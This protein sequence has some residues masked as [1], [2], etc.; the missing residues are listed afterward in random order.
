MTDWRWATGVSSLAVAGQ[1]IAYLLGIVVARNLGVAAFETYVVASAAFNLMVTFA[2]QGLEK[3]ALRVVPPLLH[4]SDWERLRGFLQFSLRRTL[5]GS[6]LVGAMVALW[7]WRQPD[8]AGPTRI[9]IAL[10]CAAVPVGAT[11]NW[12]LE[13]LTALQRPVVATAISRFGVPAM[14]LAF[15]ALAIRLFDAPGGAVAIAC[16]GIAWAVALVFMAWQFLRAVPAAQAAAAAEER[17]EWILEA[18]PF[19]IYRAMQAVLAQA[20]VVVLDWLQ[21]SAATVGAFAVASSTAA[22]AQVLATA[23]NRGYASRLSLLLDQRDYAGIQALRRQRLRWLAAPLLIYLV[24]TFG[25]ARELI[26]F[27]RPEFVEEGVAPLRLLAAATALSITLS[28]APT[29]VKFRGNNRTLYLTV[30]VSAVLYFAL[31]LSLVPIHGATGAAIAIGVAVVFTYG[32]FALL[33]HRE[34]AKLRGPSGAL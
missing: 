16:W 27:F 25:F 17:A 12:G 2:P 22:L 11:V 3:Y 21:P 7:G 15:L 5:W 1:G 13:V 18:R 19:W 20:G 9:A 33:S 8:L 6:G 31:L 14:A 23:T 10:A 28:L 24:G 30:A 4:Q 26:G 32:R 29:Y 34:L